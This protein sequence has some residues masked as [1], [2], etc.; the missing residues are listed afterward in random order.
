[1]ARAQ[2]HKIEY[3]DCA[4][5]NSLIEIW[6]EGYVG[7]V[8]ECEADEDPLNVET[9]PMDPNIFMPIVG[10]GATIRIL[11]VTEGQHR[12]MYTKQPLLKMVKIFKDDKSNPWWL[13]FV[14]PE[15]YSE[16]YSRDINY[17]VTI[18]C[19][20]G[21]NAL[22]RFKYL[23]GTAKYD[24]RETFWNVLTRILG[25]TTLPYQYIYFASKLIC[26]GVTVG[27]DETL[28]HELNANQMNYYNEL[29]EPK[30]Y[31]E[32]LEMILA[33]Y[34]LQIRQEQGS[35][36]IY[37][38]SM[39]ADASWS[40]KRFN[41]TTYAYIDTVSV[42][43]NFDI[44]NGDIDWDNEDQVYDTR[45]GYNKQK[46]RYSPYAQPGAIPERNFANRYIWTGAAEAWAA[47]A[48]GVYRLTNATR[49]VSG[50][51]LGFNAE[52]QGHKQQINSEED[53][54]IQR[55]LWQPLN[56]LLIE[57]PGFYVGECD[58]RHLVIEGSIYIRTR[59]NEFNSAEQSTL[60]DKINIPM[61][62]EIGGY[63][64]IY[65]GADWIWELNSEHIPYEQCWI[66]RGGPEG[67]S[68]ADRWV[69]FRIPVDWDNN[70][71][72]GQAVLKI[73][74]PV[75]YAPN[76]AILDADDH[77]IN[78]RFK[79]LTCKCYIGE[80]AQ[81]GREEAGSDD[82]SYEIKLDEDFENE[83]PEITL[84]HGDAADMNDRGAITKSDGAFTSAW[85]KPGDTETFR[86]VDVL[87]R[88]IASQYQDTLEILKG[89]IEADELMGVNG[90]PNF[91]HTIQDTDRM[92]SKK[93]LFGGGRYNDFRRIISEGT[94]E[95]IRQED[96]TIIVE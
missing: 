6:E 46:I 43:N 68:L 24:T 51:T 58:D 55:R 13:G 3:K 82:V 59:L 38:P 63:R 39:L 11:S 14:N 31:R 15:Q 5:V 16:P 65:D 83:G 85:S 49:G 12:G 25:K 48:Y 50:V 69:D 30:S 54:Y 95:E 40:A 4:D 53:I 64:L 96:V 1:M 91:L 26:D 84:F 8:L 79:N 36:F 10:K 7:S 90:G 67:E 35:I 93:L 62:L 75:P 61:A 47:D 87:L 70:M 78:A 18:N 72:S 17:P 88:S 73:W 76:G 41:G 80:W 27:S 71:P 20:D 77:M 89:T 22:R 44:S 23:N 57:I 66:Y 34:G 92:G 21:F 81:Q 60:I 52:L 74:Y 86:L 56:P 28:L 19:N 2:S 94:W 9:T 37:E 29:D 45:S 32:V 42:S 33:C